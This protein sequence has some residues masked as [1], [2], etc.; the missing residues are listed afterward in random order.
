M[1]ENNKQH[2]I[3]SKHPYGLLI[4]TFAEFFDRFSFCGTLT[5]LILYLTKNYFFSDAKAYAAWGA[6]NALSQITPIF[7]GIIADRILGFERSVIIGLI[8]IIA[9]NCLLGFSSL[10]GLNLG[11]SLTLCGIGL[12]KGNLSSLVGMLYKPQDPRIDNAY[13]TFFMGIVL[14]ATLGPA[15]FGILIMHYGWHI[16][17][18]LSAFGNLLSLMIFLFYRQK[19]SY[20]SLPKQ[21][22]LLM[23]KWLGKI[24]THHLFYLGLL[25]TVGMASL[26]FIYP[27]L[28]NS[29]LALISLI[30][31]LALTLIALRGS[32]IDAKQIL[33]LILLD[34]LLI[35][36]Y[37]ASMQVN[38]SLVIGIERN[39]HLQLFGWTIPSTIFASLETLFAFLLLPISAKLWTYLSRKYFAPSILF[40]IGLGHL[41]AAM[42]FAIFAWVFSSNIYTLPGLIAANLI[43][44][45]SVVCIF[46]THL[47][48]VSQY[49][50]VRIKGMLMGMSYLSSALSAYL[51]SM[52][53]AF[54]YPAKGVS[55]YTHMYMNIAVLMFAIC[56]LL[57]FISPLL[58]ALF[59]SWAEE[60]LVGQ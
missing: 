14:G 56:L 18:L 27:I 40:K 37:A 42:S 48:A 47:S 7:G 46:P 60:V 15:V 59:S 51:G 33:G 11:V 2:K 20:E 28:S 1:V 50:P 38:G 4:F 35:S 52:I 3:N 21:S 8:M 16:S 45:M 31:V 23:K 17:F 49:S 58:K 6:Y 24:T 29:I 30:A 39:F 57:V 36:Y 26:I 5:I 53:S 10:L 43:L 22:E 55:V 12:F 19:I 34:L 13:S 44:G 25:I 54:D 32:R 41:F 9:G